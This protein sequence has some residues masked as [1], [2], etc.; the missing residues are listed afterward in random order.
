MVSIMFDYDGTLSDSIGQLYAFYTHLC[1]THNK[2][3]PFTDIASFKAWF[4]E[5]YS[6][7]YEKLGFDWNRDAP[8]LQE[9]FRVFRDTAVPPLADGVL[10]LIETLSHRD[11]PLSIASN[12]FED[13]IRRELE[14]HGI[15]TRFASVRG[16]RTITDPIKPAPDLLL[17]AARHARFEPS[18][19]IYIGDA[20]SDIIAAKNAGMR[21]V[22]IT[23][24]LHT[25]ESFE[26]LEPEAIIDHP[27][28]IIALIER[29]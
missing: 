9:S 10:T 7:V 25:R 6:D 21:S 16:I 8:M 29:N 13:Q 20:V 15:L 27:S 17:D 3:A 5:P 26:A 22:G 1:T 12:G 2:H 24:G 23:T 28:Q 11:I 19:T 18:E 14:A 4:Q